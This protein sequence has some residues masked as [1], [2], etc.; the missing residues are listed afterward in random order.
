MAERRSKAK[1]GGGEMAS[2]G[3]ATQTEGSKEIKGGVN[4]TEEGE[5]GL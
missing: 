1:K 4:Q 3:E 2:G 5:R